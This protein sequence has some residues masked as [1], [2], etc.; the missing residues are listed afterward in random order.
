METGRSRGE[1]IFRNLKH[2][3]PIDI[4]SILIS[5]HDTLEMICLAY[6]KWHWFTDVM[7]PVRMVIS[8]NMS[9]GWSIGTKSIAHPDVLPLLRVSL[10]MQSESDERPS[11]KLCMESSVKFSGVIRS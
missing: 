4:E 3:F 1:T 10:K 6:L 8:D 5:R 9:P 2:K 11:P 7:K